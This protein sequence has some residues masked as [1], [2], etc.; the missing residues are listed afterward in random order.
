MLTRTLTLLAL[1]LALGACMP[2]HKKGPPPVVYQLKAPAADMMAQPPAIPAGTA[3]EVSLP[4]V[5]A[6]YDKDRIALGLDG[7]RRLDYYTN[8]RWAE[9]LPDVLQDIV[10]AGLRQSLPGL[11]VDDDESLPSPTHRLRVEVLDFAPVYAGGATSLPKARVRL[12]FA[13]IDMRANTVLLDIRQAADV[14]PEANTMGAV[15][16]ALETGLHRTLHDATPRLA[17]AL[18]PPAKPRR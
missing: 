17:A 10:S 15:T 13:L 9:N 1:T 11:V 2:F 6:G 8:A 16:A 4:A 14:M 12:R 5:P 7:G 3:V 18:A